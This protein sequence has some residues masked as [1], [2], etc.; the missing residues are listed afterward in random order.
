[1]GVDS[2]VIGAASGGARGDPAGSWSVPILIQIPKGE[3]FPVLP[4]LLISP[5]F[6]PRGFLG[7]SLFLDITRNMNW[8]YR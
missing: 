6:L 3:F 5:F 1:M 4:K 2:S 8:R 7:F